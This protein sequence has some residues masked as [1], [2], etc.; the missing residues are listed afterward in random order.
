MTRV[1]LGQTDSF[2]FKSD[3]A[4]IAKKG[5]QDIDTCR[6]RRERNDFTLATDE[7]AGETFDF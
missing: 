1:G 2:R 3:S 6:V 5:K 7:R 4:L